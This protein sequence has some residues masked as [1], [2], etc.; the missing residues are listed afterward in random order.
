[1]LAFESRA[2]FVAR[3]MRRLLRRLNFSTVAELP[4]LTGRRVDIVA[5]ASDAT[6]FIVEIKFS[7]AVFRADS[8]WRNYRAHGGAG[9]AATI[10]GLATAFGATV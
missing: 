1:M 5:L 10:P 4:L 3:G 8:N 9:P 6:I 2:L 7:V